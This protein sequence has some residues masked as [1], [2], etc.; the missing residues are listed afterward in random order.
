MPGVIDVGLTAHLPM[1]GYSWT[2]NARRS[3]RPLASGEVA[4]TVGWRFI[5]CDYLQRMR[6]PLKSARRS[7][8]SD[9]TRR[10]RLR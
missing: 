8:A 5:H 9:V 4:P 7:Q 1:S 3:D 6:I 10:R 2:T